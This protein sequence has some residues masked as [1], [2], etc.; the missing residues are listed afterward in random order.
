M[1]CCA[2]DVLGRARVS[3]SV[4]LGVGGRASRRWR[5]SGGRRQASPL[6]AAAAGLA[7]GSW[8]ATREAVLRG[9][10]VLQPRVAS[11]LPGS[12]CRAFWKKVRAMAV[13][14]WARA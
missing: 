5:R 12:S 10:A 6:A 13:A 9:L 4:A 3:S 11:A 1:S 8:K 2:G 7:A 14:P